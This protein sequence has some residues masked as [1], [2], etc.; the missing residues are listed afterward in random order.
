M[1]W[2]D[3]LKATVGLSEKKAA[4]RRGAIVGPTPLGFQLARIGGS[5]T[6]QLVSCIIR[7]ADTGQVARLVDLENES[8]QR[9][10]HLQ[11]ILGTREQAVSGLE[12]EIVAPDGEDDKARNKKVAEWCTDVIDRLDTWPTLLAHLQGAVYFGHAVAE[13]LWAKVTGDIVPVDFS[14]IAP[15]RFIFDQASQRI[16]WWDQSGGHPLPGVDIA[17]EFPGRFI[18]HQ[19][20]VN[21]DSPCREGL[22]R[23]LMWAALFRNW[24]QRDWLS[25]AELAWKPW[26]TGKYV[27]GADQEDIEALEEAL[28][29]MSTSGVAVLPETTELEVMFP[30]GGGQ[31]SN[32]GELMSW[33]GAEMS[34]AVLGATTTVEQGDRGA[35]A[36]GKVHNEIRK[37]IRDSDAKQLAATIRRDLLTPLVRMNY[38]PNVAVPVFR[39]LTEDAID[40]AAFSQAIGSLRTAGLRIP[41][42]HVYDI[43]GIPEPKDDDELLGDHAAE[44]AAEMGLS[45]DGKPLPKD[46]EEPGEEKPAAKPD[47]KKPAK[48]ADK[49]G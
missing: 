38:G 20:R 5:L 12:H 39:F 41:A 32:H 27:K 1:R 19:P 10:C 43:S 33:L 8:R 11:S 24:N 49:S 44:M 30:A 46:E 45:P 18:V 17:K 15:R 13:P 2:W 7:E 47:A 23:V 29:K 6:P 22:G 16:H 21:G 4:S 28:D 35:L 25:L 9:D 40:L 36:L 34:K 3:R 48:P 14:L 26:R 37:D 31:R 42:C